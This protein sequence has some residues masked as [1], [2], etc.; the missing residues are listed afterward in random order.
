MKP[1]KKKSK[2]NEESEDD[3]G[4]CQQ[5]KPEIAESEEGSR[6]R[7]ESDL[8]QAQGLV[9]FFYLCKNKNSTCIYCRMY[10]DRYY[11]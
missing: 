10:I 7:E 3:E 11:F 8:S 1:L 9:Y 5:G 2:V 6:S 4:S